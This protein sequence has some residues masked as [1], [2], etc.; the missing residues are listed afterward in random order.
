[1]LYLGQGK[2][3]GQGQELL[4][5]ASINGRRQLCLLRAPAV[6]LPGEAPRVADSCS[7]FKDKRDPSG[8]EVSLLGWA[9][10]EQLRT[11]RWS[12][13]RQ[14]TLPPPLPWAQPDRVPEGPCLVTKSCWVIVVAAVFNDYTPNS[15][16]QSTSS[17]RSSG[18]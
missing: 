14:L 7:V 16:S 2:S 15:S 12:L 5:W 9:R 6:N 8:K 18:V 17:S 11:S 1:M 3:Q 13:N 10:K 4:T